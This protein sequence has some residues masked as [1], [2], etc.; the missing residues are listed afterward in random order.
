MKTDLKKEDGRLY[1]SCIFYN[2]VVEQVD[3]ANI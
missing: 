1:L 3:T 2:S